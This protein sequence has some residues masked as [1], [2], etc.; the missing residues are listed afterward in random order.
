MSC[1]NRGTCRSPAGLILEP[2]AGD[3]AISADGIVARY[4]DLIRQRDARAA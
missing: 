3:G 4:E 1:T 2:S